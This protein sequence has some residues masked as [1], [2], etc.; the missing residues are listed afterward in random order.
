MKIKKNCKRFC[1]IKKKKNVD[2]AESCVVREYLREYII[3]TK[4]IT[5]RVREKKKIKK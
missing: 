2:V 1:F 3:I 5:V 4:I